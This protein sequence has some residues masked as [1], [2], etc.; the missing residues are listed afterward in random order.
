MTAALS[1]AELR[2]QG[3]GGSDQAPRLGISPFTTPLQLQKEKLGEGETSESDAMWFGT[4]MEG[5]LADRF[6][7]ETGLRLRRSNQT[8][9]HKRFPHCFAHID[10][11]VEGA[12]EFVE[13]KTTS[14]SEDWEDGD[15]PP[16]YLAQ[17]QHYLEVTG[18]ERAHAYVL[19]RH[20]LKT[21]HIVVERD[22]ALGE[23]LCAGAHEWYERHVVNREPVAPINAE[24][25]RLLYQKSNGQSIEA[26]GELI[27]LLKQLR[28]IKAQQDGIEELREPIVARIQEL[29]GENEAAVYGGKP[30]V[31]WKSSDSQRVDISR[32][33][34]ERPDV[35]A[36]FVKT[37][38]S[39]RFLP[40]WPRLE[41]LI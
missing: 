21:K 34:K 15:V 5:P 23:D 7:A 41:D 20:S 17:V 9:K 26:D 40:K 10:R 8:K 11:K 39:R 25:V 37:T 1:F 33:R 30:L 32:L 3:M 22:K 19:F 4:V 12:P 36:E 24:D 14:K 35:A 38:Q 13:I 16:Y 6:E 18:Y 29:L 27:E 31:T 28:E 2:R